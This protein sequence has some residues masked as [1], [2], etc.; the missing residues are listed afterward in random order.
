MKTSEK[1]ETSGMQSLK[2][3]KHVIYLYKFKN[4]RKKFS[5]RL[6][7]FLGSFSVFSKQLLLRSPCVV[8]SKLLVS[9]YFS[10]L[11]HEVLLLL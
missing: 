3:A 8:G 10:T 6:R 5:A 7:T 11:Y 9:K 1:N 2:K 4:I